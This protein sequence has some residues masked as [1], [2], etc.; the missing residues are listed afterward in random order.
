MFTPIFEKDEPD[1]YNGD[2]RLREVDLHIRSI[3]D[4][5]GMAAIDRSLNGVQVGDLD[6][7]VGRAAFAVDAAL[8]TIRRAAEW[9]ADLLFVHHGLF[10]GSDVPITGD[11][12][13][14]IKLLL[15]DGVALYAAH[16]PLDKH[17]ELGNNAQMAAALGLD[18]V[19]PFGE[20]KGTT[21][22]VQGTLPTPTG[23]ES[24]AATLFGS[25]DAPIAMLPFGPEANQ[26]VAI[27]SGGAPHQ[28][29]EAI[30]AGVDCYVTGDASHV[31]YHRCL[32]AGINVIFGGH[33]LTETWGPQAM[34]RRLQSDI[35]LET[36][37]IDL[38]T[39]L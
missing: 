25:P 18:S 22:G 7:E 33:Y 11:H 4:I 38:P 27:V 21:I 2:M 13:N 19:A 36:T 14:R 16:L 37:F 17:A 8:E 24:L 9:G 29:D 23:I 12:Y 32:E 5:D 10:W 6:G 28:V 26:T 1:T 15:D 30:A 3:L 31:I 20:Y 35:R 34:M 39:G